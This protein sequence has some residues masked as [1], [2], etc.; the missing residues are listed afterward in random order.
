MT[1]I[2]IAGLYVVLSFVQALVM[3]RA[4]NK[5]NPIEYP[6]ITVLLF[7]LLGLGAT[8]IFLAGIISASIELFVKGRA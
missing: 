2:Q 3:A 8:V 6:K 7:T 1:G 5:Q 4:M